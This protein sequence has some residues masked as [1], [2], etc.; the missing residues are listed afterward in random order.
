MIRN[1]AD[2]HELQVLIDMKTNKKDTEYLMRSIDVIH[3]QVVH[4]IVVMIEFIRTNIKKQ[5]E[6]K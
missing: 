2:K 4:I 5:K 3:K 6:S 1:K